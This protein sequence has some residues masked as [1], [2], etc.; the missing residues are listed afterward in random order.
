L[1]SGIDHQHPALL[2]D[3][4][5]P[6]P[7]YPKCVPRDCPYTS[8]KVI[9]ARSYVEMLAA[10]TP[11]N[12]AEDS[13]PDDPT[14]RDR[15]GHGTAVAVIAAGREVSTPSATISGVAP[16]RSWATTRFSVRRAST[17]PLMATS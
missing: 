9:V 11:P 3:S 15:V 1:D 5:R 17:T 4:L 2:D 10:G 6:P 8:N 14:P 7:G 16:K 12:P 13:R